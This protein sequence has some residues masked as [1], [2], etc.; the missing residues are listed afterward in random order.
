MSR[1]EFA[2]YYEIKIR[3]FEILDTLQEVLTPKGKEVHAKQKEW[4]IAN[5]D[6]YVDSLPNR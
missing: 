2:E 1:L 3:E 4:L 5:I 6:K